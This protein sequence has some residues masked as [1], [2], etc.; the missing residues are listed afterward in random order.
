MV[1][2]GTRDFFKSCWSPTPRCCSSWSA[3]WTPWCRCSRENHVLYVSKPPFAPQDFTGLWGQP[4]AG[5]ARGVVAGYRRI[6][7]S[8]SMD[9]QV[10]KSRWLTC[11][12]TN[13]SRLLS[14]STGYSIRYFFLLFPSSN[15]FSIPV[16]ESTGS[17]IYLEFLQVW[18]KVR[19][20]Y[21]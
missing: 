1:Q 21:L 7:M 10:G 16:S 14:S 17:C 4:G 19:P 13:S 5:A 3:R 11:V 20:S 2:P 12:H 8:C 6:L 9:Q 15:Y 18:P